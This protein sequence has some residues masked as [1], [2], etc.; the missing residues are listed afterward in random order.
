M[1][2]MTFLTASFLLSLSM[3]RSSLF[4]SATSPFFVVAK[5]LPSIVFCDSRGPSTDRRRVQNV[6][7]EACHAHVAWTDREETRRMVAPG[8]RC[9]ARSTHERPTG[10]AVLCVPPEGGTPEEDPPVDRSAHG[11]RP[12]TGKTAVHDRSL[13]SS[14][15]GENVGD[16]SPRPDGGGPGGTEGVS[17]QKGG[18][19]V[20]RLR[21]E[22]ER[23]PHEETIRKREWTSK[24]SSVKGVPGGSEEVLG[25]RNTP[26]DR[27]G[28]AVDHVGTHRIRTGSPRSDARAN[29]HPGDAPAYG[30]A[31]LTTQRNPSL[32][33]SER[34]PTPN[35]RTEPRSSFEFPPVY[36]VFSRS[37]IGP[38]LLLLPTWGRAQ[39]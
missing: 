36:A 20:G 16:T 5:Y 12:K 2:A 14:G 24:H 6:D 32:R 37:M 28:E 22:K 4:H 33:S 34:A 7:G 35:V 26:P 31:V 9:P 30:R 27:E 25:W 23:F 10:I 19:G 29:Q 39:G 8:P 3:L 18:G 15:G 38:P 1:A 11:P 17:S 13:R 21:R